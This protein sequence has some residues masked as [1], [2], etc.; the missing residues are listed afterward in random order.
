MVDQAK[1]KALAAIRDRSI[2]K[3]GKGRM[4]RASNLEA[5][6]ERGLARTKANKTA[7]RA[8][9]AAT[10]NPVGKTVARTVPRP[11]TINHGGAMQRPAPAVGKNPPATRQVPKTAPIVA[12]KKVPIAARSGVT[13]PKSALPMARSVPVA[14]RKPGVAAKRYAR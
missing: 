5:T 4:Q 11:T 3:Y 14:P 2:K 13:A 6:Y 7:S 8:S 9:A 12:A 10:P 1:A